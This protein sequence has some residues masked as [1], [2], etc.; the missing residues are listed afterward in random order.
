MINLIDQNTT[1][2]Q[3]NCILI[4]EKYP[5]IHENANE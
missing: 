2:D 1:L 3:E 4:I 5:L